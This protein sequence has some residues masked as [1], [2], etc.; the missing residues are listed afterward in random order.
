MIA[1]GGRFAYST[2]YR[3]ASL[4]AVLTTIMSRRRRN[5]IQAL[6]EAFAELPKDFSAAPFVFLNNTMDASVIGHILDDLCEKGFSTVVLSP[7]SGLTVPFASDEYWQKLSTIVSHAKALSLKVWLCVDYHQPIGMGA[8]CG[9]PIP[10]DLCSQSLVFRTGRHPDANEHVIGTYLIRGRSVTH[11]PRHPAKTKCLIVSTTTSNPPTPHSSNAKTIP[12]GGMGR[13]DILNP[14]AIRYYISSV[15]ESL[16]ANLEEYFGNTIVGILIQSPSNQC[17]FPWTGSLPDLFKKRFGYD[18]VPSL[19]SLIED[20]GNRITVRTNYYRLISD[21]TGAFYSAIKDWAQEHNLSFSATIGRE[22]FIETLPHTQ[23]DPYAVLSEMSIPAT[24][25]RCAENQYLSDTP[26]SLAQN[27]TPKIISSVA[28]ISKEGRALAA[29]WEGEGWGATP[30]LLKQTI[31]CGV[32]LGITSFFTHGVFPSIIGLRKRDFPPSFYRQMPYWDDATIL[33]DYISRTCLVMSAGHSRAD[34]LI[35]FPITS[36][37]ANT[38]GLDRLTKNGKNITSG[39]NDLIRRLLSDQRDFDFLY[40]EM[41]ERRMVRC[42]GG[43]V[44]IGSNRYSTLVIP[45]ATDIPASVFTFAENAKKNGVNVIFVGEYP[46]IIDKQESPTLGIG[47]TLVTDAADLIHYLRQ[48]TARHLSISGNNS[49]KFLYQRRTFSGADIYFVTYLG[50]EQFSGTFTLAGA[51]NLEAWNPEDGRRYG[52]SEFQLTGGGI[53]FRVTFEP[54]KSWIYVIHSEYTDTLHGLPEPHGHRIGEFFF[55]GRW[56]VDYRSDNMLRIDSF[57][58]IRSSPPVPLSPV[59]D[60]I[61]DDRFGLFSKIVIGLVRFFTESIGRVWGI[62]RKIG[63]RSFTSMEREIA[64]YLTAARLGGL[65][66]TAQAHYRQVDLV[67]DAAR[68]MGLFL[69]TPLPPEGSEFEIEANFIVGHIPARI[70]LV[71]EDY[72]EPTEIF[73]NGI[74][75]SDRAESCFVWDRHNKRADLSDIIRWGTNRIGIRSHQPGF[76]SVI[77]TIHCVEPVVITGEF[78]VNM[79]IITARKETTRHL[80]WGRNA[81]G[82]YSGT[83]TFTSRFHLPQRFAGNT[84]ILE[85]GDVRVS[86]RVILNGHDL[87]AKIWPPY[88][89]D[90]TNV[91]S[92]GENDIEI[93]VTN[94]AE[95]LLGTPILS[96]IVTD[97]KIIFFNP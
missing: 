24:S 87:G 11:L 15:L 31:D 58:L 82:N 70:F 77:P 38:V 54:G 21:L 16:R 50:H 34:I 59:N 19:P 74:L 48:N 43:D 46:D 29:V 36:L 90:I 67:R 35:L 25:Y 72:G 47:I 60:F 64:F 53:S 23:G 10:P 45:W 65:T 79:D 61:R 94:T 83:V 42:N 20:V 44:V 37:W 69:S 4:V 2:A 73:I 32:S 57:R 12:H 71:W 78:D 97:P 95:N 66:A 13:L 9:L 92:P 63:Y 51:G 96:G 41:I 6:Y 14:D 93:S 26:P 28:H 80:S 86:C 52:I 85:L 76:P 68:H 5:K 18:L 39:L 75:V 55:P 30:R 56:K 62:R 8:V 17:P 49:D 91:L 27:F 22:G 81:T 1:A 7:R 88:R 89:F 33:T 84:A 3:Q 40:E